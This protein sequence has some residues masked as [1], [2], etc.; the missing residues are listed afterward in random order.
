MEIRWLKIAWE[1]SCSVIEGHV[2]HN[3]WS[4][5]AA[6]YGHF[7]SGPLLPIDR[8]ILPFFHKFN[9]VD[10]QL[11]FNVY[12]TIVYVSELVIIGLDKKQC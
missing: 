9:L 6:T 1:I 10:I 2:C 12:E 5:I 4:Y 8:E 7:N 3:S 11:E